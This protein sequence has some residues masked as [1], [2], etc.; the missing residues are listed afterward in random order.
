MS[1]LNF[2]IESVAHYCNS[3]T[4]NSMPLIVF[5]NGDLKMKNYLHWA[6]WWSWDEDGGSQKFISMHCVKLS[7]LLVHTA[8]LPEGILR[9]NVWHNRGGVYW[10]RI[11]AKSTRGKKKKNIGSW[12]G[13]TSH[14]NI[15]YF[16]FAPRRWWNL[17]TS[18]HSHTVVHSLFE[19]TNFLFN[20]WK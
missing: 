6:P 8:A 18:I 9:V 16:S 20:K 1:A 10:D 15:I 17:W 13:K 14:F 5:A 12:R 4:K 11:L 7:S 19:I 3:S 2:S